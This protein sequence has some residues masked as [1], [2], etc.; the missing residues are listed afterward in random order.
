MRLSKPGNHGVQR[1]GCGVITGVSLSRRKEAGRV[2][3]PSA[4]ASQVR[5]TRESGCASPYPGWE[6]NDSKRL[7][8]A[9]A[10][11]RCVAGPS[12]LDI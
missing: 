8:H 4:K 10:R 11:G 1:S 3:G 12:P 7:P 9:E 6:S 2:M 5:L